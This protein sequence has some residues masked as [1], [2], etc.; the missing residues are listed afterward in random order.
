MPRMTGAEPARWQTALE[1]RV[2]T[3][4]HQLA[5]VKIQKN[6]VVLLSVLWV[7]SLSRAPRCL[8]DTECCERGELEKTGAWLSNGHPL[9]HR[10][11]QFSSQPPHNGEEPQCQGRSHGPHNSRSIAPWRYR[12]DCDSARFPRRLLQAE[13]LCPHCVSLAPPHLQ[14]RRGNSV[15][16]NTNTTVYYRRPCPGQA[17]AY[18][19]EPRLYPLAVACICVV[20]QF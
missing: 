2:T 8:G 20:P 4:K 9:G 11:C 15:P 10:S 7:G 14:D 5:K 16:V 1:P 13:C 6:M 19:L 17:G 12:E 18:F 3:S